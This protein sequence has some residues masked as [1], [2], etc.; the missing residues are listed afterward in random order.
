[1]PAGPDRSV[2]RADY[3]EQ[4]ATWIEDAAE[5]LTPLRESARPRHRYDGT[6]RLGVLR[7]HAAFESLF[8]KPPKRPRA[9]WQAKARALQTKLDRMLAKDAAHATK[10]E[11]AGAR[12]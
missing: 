5:A 6:T 9:E 7:H 11:T 8:A 1:V 10:S 2:E 12:K 4:T 3:V